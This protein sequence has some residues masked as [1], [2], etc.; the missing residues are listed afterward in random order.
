[1]YFYIR[2]LAS[3]LLVSLAVCPLAASAETRD[4]MPAGIVLPEPHEVLME[5]Q[6]MSDTNILQVLVKEDPTP[7][8]VE[9][10]AALEAGG[11]EINDSAVANGRLLFS[12][13]EVEIGG[14]NVQSLDEAEFMIQIDVTK[15]ED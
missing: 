15:A 12:S 4:W 13:P 9:W 3:F 2:Q 1:M 8:F 7:L 14:I 11:Y 10:R 5:Q 6:I